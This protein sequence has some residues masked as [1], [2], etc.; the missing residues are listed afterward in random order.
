MRILVVEDERHAF[1]S[2]LRVLKSVVADADVDGP[3]RDTVALREVLADPS[4]RYDLI[5][6]DIHLQDDLCFDVLRGADTDTPVIYTTAYDR[7]A[8]D[9][10]RS[11]GIDYLLKPIDKEEL[12]KAIDKALRFNRGRMEEDG[13]GKL[14]V[15]DAWGQRV[16]EAK[17]VSHIVKE[18][19]TIAA[20]M[21]DGSS[22][23]MEE[24]S[25][26]EVEALLDPAAF[27][28]ANRQTIVGVGDIG[29]VTNDHGQRKVIRLLSYQGK[30]VIV[31]KEKASSF[32]EWL[33]TSFG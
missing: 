11:G 20:Y 17:A 9:A 28:R 1:D 18:E 5:L 23:M 16:V 25:L 15:R 29:G 7:Y 2:T 22:F 4:R 3:V 24:R 30:P 13:R 14:L 6:A 33:R 8:L 12:R 10:F 26:D 19:G 27:F 31:S 21:R 32:M